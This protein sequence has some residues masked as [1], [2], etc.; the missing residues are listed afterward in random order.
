VNAARGRESVPPGPSSP[1]DIQA[2]PVAFEVLPD[3]FSKF[4]DIYSVPSK[5]GAFLS[6]VV[7]H[8]DLIRHVLVDNSRN[9]AKGR[10][11]DRVK[12]L[13][14]NGI[15][16]S[17]GDFWR[18]QRRMIQPAF[19]K[20]SLDRIFALMRSCHIELIERWTEYARTGQRVDVVDETSRL[21]L[22][23][24]TRATFGARLSDVLGPNSE[25]PFSLLA[26]TTARDLRFVSRFRA[27]VPLVIRAMSAR[28][29]D[30]E[31]L[32]FLSAIMKA[33]DT[34]G[35]PMEQRAAVDEILTLM[36]SGHET[37]AASLAWV[38][39][40]VTQNPSCELALR[41]EVENNRWSD[42]PTAADLER[43]VHVKRTF[44]EALRMYPP[45]WV[46]TRRALA[47]D[48]IGG[49]RVPAD[50][51]VVISPYI[52]H[53]RTDFWDQPGSFI[54]ERFGSSGSSLSSGAFIP[55]SS[56]PRKCIGE[57]FATTTAE[58][59]IAS[60]MRHFR[61]TGA[62]RVVRPIAGVNL[63]PEEPIWVSLEA[64]TAA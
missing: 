14:G 6:Y 5:D 56:G 2:D 33:R 11:F 26:D 62:S 49:Y 21:A 8:P 42:L 7:N 40:L 63:R 9:Y 35:N 18:R 27:L 54:P 47:D 43:L 30:D 45:G 10:G 29:P 24:I 13:L 50:S 41:G 57:A 17:Q 39:Y 60:V 28:K 23:V 20:S 51:E 19:S 32:D 53:R 46:F 25:N 52:V 3:W 38:W 55:F 36:V 37:T 1:M 22:S 48:V 61:L 34:F 58:T 4:G 16:V 31:G 15:F 44:L 59:H 12:L 64:S